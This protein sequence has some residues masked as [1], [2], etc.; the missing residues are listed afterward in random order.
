M[1]FNQP[2]YLLLL[3]VL[4]GLSFW[5]SKSNLKPLGLLFPNAATFRQLS[6]KKGTLAL[7][8]ITY[9]RYA[10]LILMIIALAMPQTHYSIKKKAPPHRLPY[11]T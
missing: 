1:Q 5:T 2:Y 8:I 9:S 10:A 4:G 7:K 11:F 3:L 6:D